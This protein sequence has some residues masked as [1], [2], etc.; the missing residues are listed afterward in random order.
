[1]NQ[2]GFFKLLSVVILMH[3]IL[4]AIVS[5]IIYYFVRKIGWIKDGDMKLDFF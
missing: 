1:M 3:I 4:P 2:V 5:L